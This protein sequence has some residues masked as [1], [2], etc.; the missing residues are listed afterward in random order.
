MGYV[1][2]KVQSIVEQNTHNICNE[3]MYEGISICL[4]QLAQQKDIEDYKVICM[5]LESNNKQT[6]KSQLTELEQ[7]IKSAEEIVNNKNS[8]K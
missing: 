5:S 4:L 1:D 6:L 8:T 7:L 3:P 2:F